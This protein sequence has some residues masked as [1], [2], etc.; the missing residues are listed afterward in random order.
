VAEAHVE[1]LKTL[2]PVILTP[3]SEPAPKGLTLRTLMIAVAVCAFAIWLTIKLGLLILLAAFLFVITIAIALVIMLAKQHASQQE[4]FL[5]SLAIA[6]ERSM[7]LPPAALAFADQFGATFRWRIQLF[8]SLLEEGIPFPAAIDH[9]PEL[10][11]RDARVMVKTGWSSGRFA[12]GLREAAAIRSARKTIWGAIGGQFLY[13]GGLL[14]AMQCT[15]GFL[16]YFIVPKFEAIF[17]DFGIALPTVTRSTIVMSHW[18]TDFLPVT[19]LLI[20]LELT[21]FF[22]LPLG[23]LNVFQWDI[24]PLDWLFRRRH[25]TLILRALALSA[26]GAQPIAKAVEALTRDYP[27][28]WVRGRLIAVYNDLQHGEDWVHSLESRGLIR[29]VDAAVLGSAVKVGNLP[30]AMRECAESADRRLGYRLQ[31][32]A[33]MV[34]PLMLVGLGLLVLMFCV[35]YFYPIVILIQRLAG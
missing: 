18:L 12:E 11:S 34:A 6:A 5:L 1:T 10:L 8:A 20:V 22:F 15:A 13:L 33:Q 17:M 24:P 16:M 4:A 32:L 3:V 35:A 28:S 7:P 31:I 27:S 21:V 30:W 2:D 19:V 29:D 25:S 26:D 9:V 14:A 23:L